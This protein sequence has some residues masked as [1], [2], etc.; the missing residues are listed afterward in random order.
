[1][2]AIKCTGAILIG[3][4]LKYSETFSNCTLYIKVNENAI[5]TYDVYGYPP[6]E[7]YVILVENIPCSYKDKLKFKILY[8]AFHYLYM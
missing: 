3:A 8:I 7:L 4:Y 6:E 5:T 2:P 1:M